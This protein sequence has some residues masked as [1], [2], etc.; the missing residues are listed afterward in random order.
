MA[1]ANSNLSLQ[2]IFNP[3]KQLISMISKPR[4][5]LVAG[6]DSGEYVIS[7]QSAKVLHQT[8][9]PELFDVYP[10]HIKGRK[11]Q[12]V[13][14]EGHLFDVDKNDFSILLPQG[15]VNFDLAFITI[16]GTPGEDGKLQGYFDLIGLPYSTSGQLACALSFNKF[17][18]NRAVKSFGISTAHSIKLKKEE[19]EQTDRVL[20]EVRL[21]FFVK[22]NQ[23]GSSL[24]TSRV[25]EASQLKS[26]LQAAF[27]HDTEVLIEEMISGTELTCGVYKQNGKI[28]TLPVTEIVSKSQSAFFDYEA[29][30]KGLSEEI[31]PAR[32]S[33]TLSLKIQELAKT[34]Y[35]KLELR[36]VARIDFIYNGLEP[37]FLEAN[38]TP[39]MSQA[40]IVP[41]QAQV[42]GYSFREFMTILLQEALS[43][44]KV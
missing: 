29:K 17:F 40:S 15:K 36:G 22:P 31:T 21:P 4:I 39:G 3:N 34:V 32:I 26:A 37:V 44:S 2:K 16:H 19:I 35:E 23:G 11:W 6:G 42:A 33:E 18:C 30:Y 9:D 5:A 25:D 28:M 27:E 24:G 20:N 1:E 7:V 10:I 38:I 13:D 43:F 8:I 14:A 41:Q 12:Y